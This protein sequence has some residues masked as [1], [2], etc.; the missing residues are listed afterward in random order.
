MRKHL[1]LTIALLCAV[2]QG[3]W[4][5]EPTWTEVGDKDAL[6]S[7]IPTMRGTTCRAARLLA[8]L[9]RLARPRMV[10]GQWSMVN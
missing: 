1:L 8:R 2:V 5:Q 6:I 3:A 7:R 9:R 10:N 4:A